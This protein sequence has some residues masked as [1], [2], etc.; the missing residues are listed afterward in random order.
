MRTPP[1]AHV[2]VCACVCVLITKWEK[3][4][5]SGYDTKLYKVIRLKFWGMWRHPLLPLL[6]GTLLF[7]EYEDTLYCHYSK[8]H[9]DFENMKTPFFAITPRY[10]LILRIWRHP[11]LPLL[12]GTLWFW[13][14]ED[15]LLC[16]Y[17][18]VHSDFDNM[19]T[20]FFA[21]TPRYT[22]I[23]RIWRHPLLPLLQGT[24]WFWEY[25]DTLYCHYSKVHSDFEN[26]KTPFIAITPRY[27]LILRIKTP[28]IAITPRYTLILR[29]WRHP[30]LPLLQGTL[31]FWEY[32]DTLYCHYSK[33]HFDF[34]NMKTPF[35]AITPRYTLILRIWR[36]PL[37]PLLQGTLW[38]WEYE[39]TL[40]CHYSKVHSDFENMKTP[41]IAI[42]PRYTLIL[43][44]WRHPLLPLLQGTL[45]FWEYEDTLYC[46][47]SKVLS[48]FENV[49]T[50]QQCHFFLNTFWLYEVVFAIE[51]YIYTDVILLYDILFFF[52]IMVRV[53][54]NGPGDLGS[55]PGQVIPKT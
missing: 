14:Y 31:W 36:H 1:H 33:V 26:M 2:C 39:D 10:T 52:G 34:E 4:K 32:E 44:I 8:V 37:L 13:E 41:F 45:W 24:L 3:N 11:L 54:T 15:T 47:Y 46:H 19:K 16:H 51:I 20:P 28:F 42:T 23:L 30:L 5:S 21:I 50:L 22:L 27:T 25:E 29:I 48:D 38:F 35:I 17:S 53:F 40:Y 43:R 49:T 7:W 12:Q 18:K 55:I 6:Q 9:S